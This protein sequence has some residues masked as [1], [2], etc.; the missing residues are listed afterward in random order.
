MLPLIQS[1][2]PKWSQILRWYTSNLRS[3]VSAC[4]GYPLLSKDRT[5]YPRIKRCRL[6]PE[7][8]AVRRSPRKS[9]FCLASSF[10]QSCSC[11]RPRVRCS[12]VSLVC[13]WIPWLWASCPSR[14]RTPHLLPCASKGPQT[15]PG[16]PSRCHGQLRKSDLGKGPVVRCN[17][18]YLGS[19]WLWFLRYVDCYPKNEHGQENLLRG[20][21]G[22]RLK[23]LGQ[24]LSSRRPLSRFLCHW[25]NHLLLFLGSSSARL[26]SSRRLR[27]ASEVRLTCCTS[28]H[29]GSWGWLWQRESVLLSRSLGLCTRSLASQI[30]Q[31]E[32]Q[33]FMYFQLADWQ[34]LMLSKSQRKFAHQ[35]WFH[36]L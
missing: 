36:L 35:C 5:L 20:S 30:S 31:L 1:H 11:N 6:D 29:Q 28:L 26:E 33:W 3:S 24:R 8:Y 7:V 9:E 21:H 27:C 17:A 22:Y 15:S 16:C 13:P 32:D 19:S 4:W 18:P 25:T 2:F 10:V 34:S 23:S 14:S 12:Q